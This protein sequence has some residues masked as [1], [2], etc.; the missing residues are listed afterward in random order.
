M[1]TIEGNQ[2]KKAAALPAV[3]P[4]AGKADKS[5]KLEVRMREGVTLDQAVADMAA[6]GLAGNAALTVWYSNASYG[7]ELSL[8][9]MV[10]SLETTG[11]AVNGG[12]LQAAEQ[13]LMA[14]SISLNAIY[15]ELARRAAMQMGTYPDAFE[16]Y[17]R[18][19]LK[20]QGQCR[21]TLESLAAIKNPPVV[22]AKQAN[23]AHGSQQ[24]NNAEQ[25]LVNPPH[26]AGKSTN[27]TNELMRAEDG[28]RMDA[29][30]Q[31]EASGIDPWLATVAAINR[32]KV[33][34]RQGSRLQEQ[35]Q[36]RRSV[37]RSH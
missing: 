31:G 35:P 10:R 17:M 9:D 19:A 28:S 32:P 14:Q 25:Q 5:H 4:D 6:A 36:A 22:F 3:S 1:K 23:I 15:T 26:P 13:T 18:L 2:A 8:S 29:G 11:K 20:A 7:G 24:V 37:R 12:S 27:P 16:R 21:T 33:G 30:A 34:Y